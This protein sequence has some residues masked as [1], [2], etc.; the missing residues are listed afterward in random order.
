MKRG[1]EREITSQY[2]PSVPVV[3]CTVGGF[4]TVAWLKNVLR[5]EAKFSNCS[6]LSD[7]LF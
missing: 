6:G 3:A 1:K 2:L 5:D 7:Q 4:D